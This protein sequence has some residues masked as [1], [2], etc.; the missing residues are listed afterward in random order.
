MGSLILGELR[1]AGDSVD[2]PLARDVVGEASAL[3]EVADGV[4]DGGV[5][6]VTCASVVSDF[7]KHSHCRADCQGGGQETEDGI[8]KLHSD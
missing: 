6:R 3:A 2:G 8:E 5:G 1:V 4:G 7:R